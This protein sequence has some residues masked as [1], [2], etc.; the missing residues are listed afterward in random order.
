MEQDCMCPNHIQCDIVPFT[1]TSEVVLPSYQHHLERDNHIKG[2][3]VNESET[4]NQYAKTILMLIL[5]RANG[6]Y[7]PY[8]ASPLQRKKKDVSLE[9]SLP[10]L[11]RNSSSIGS[12]V[13]F[14][15]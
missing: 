8:S 4:L 5:A 11:R 3:K 7:S 14:T 10:M 1:L 6:Y 9:I 13:N 2:A 15:R 12:R